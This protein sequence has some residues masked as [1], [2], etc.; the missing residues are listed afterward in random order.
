[1]NPERLR[2]NPALVL[3]TS[4][5][6]YL[7]YEPASGRVHQLNATA[8]LLI[9]LCDGTR[10]ASDLEALLG[11]HLG[12]SAAAEICA[13]LE[14]ARRERLVEG[15][16]GAPG[17]AGEAHSS[18]ALA[19]LAEGLRERGR[20]LA[21]YV[22]Q[23]GVVEARPDDAGAWSQL[24]ELAHIVG[25]RD[26]ARVAYEAYQRLRP[27]DAEVA[28]LLRALRDD[29]P[30][31]RA[32]DDCITQL[33]ARFAGF[34]DES[35]GDDLGY[36]APG[37]VAEA[38]ATA[39]GDR[40]DLAVLDLGCG[41]G[42]AGQHLRPRARHLVGVDLSPEML[43]RARRRRLYDRLDEAEI[44]AWLGADASSAGPDG[45]FDLIVAC[46]ALI[47]FGDL[48][49]VIGPAAALLAPGGWFVGTVER[50]ER[51][52]LRLTDSGRYAHHRDHLAATA[53]AAGLT[54]RQLDEVVLRHEYGEPVVGLLA[55]FGAPGGG[56]A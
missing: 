15:L 42:L 9:E 14:R 8:A 2:R 38:V 16:D 48:G 19:T 23:R 24:G 32:P 44:T 36:Q 37:L 54:V 34:Y 26:E 30:P 17:P 29:A 52:P 22:C 13:W 28:H 50:S 35:M 10:T 46:D 33:Y 4:D 40:R 21:A 39:I 3:A 49:Q 25:R 27:G 7:A 6:G 5:A 1:M 47:Y 45:R 53:A 55:V 31:A 41:T 12:E 51:A 56:V 11:P 18:E 20:V 43:A